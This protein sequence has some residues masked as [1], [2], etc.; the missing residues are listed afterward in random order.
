MAILLYVLQA[1][2]Y[3]IETSESLFFRPAPHGVAIQH[4]GEAWAFNYYPLLI[5]TLYRIK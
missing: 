1:T 5:S 4:H 3:V 2:E